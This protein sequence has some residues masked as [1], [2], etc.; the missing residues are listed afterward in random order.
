MPA[1]QALAP[2]LV[3]ASLL[4]RAT[5]FNSAGTEVA[6][7]GGPALGGLVFVAGASAVY[8][9]CLALLLLASAMALRL[10]Y[11]HT[12]PAH[13]PVTLA[14]VFAG[15]DLCLA[16]QT[17]IGC[18][19][20]GSFRCVARWRNRIAADLCQRHLLLSTGSLPCGLWIL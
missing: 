13:E 9:L 18:G 19:V 1:Q 8:G 20:A 5:A 16:Q 15:L 12:P 10:Q 11:R 2:L 17:F 14:S 7:I 6:V 3:P 4:P